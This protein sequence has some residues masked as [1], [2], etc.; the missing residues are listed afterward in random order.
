VKTDRVCEN[1]EHVRCAKIS[2]RAA[3]LV[4]YVKKDVREKNSAREDGV[5]EASIS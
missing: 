3:N 5:R 1:Y 2:A 4:P